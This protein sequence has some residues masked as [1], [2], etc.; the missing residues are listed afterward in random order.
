MDCFWGVAEPDASC[1]T[2]GRLQARFRSLT[3][4]HSD[5]DQKGRL[6]EIKSVEKRLVNVQTVTGQFSVSH[7]KDGFLFLPPFFFFKKPELL[8]VAVRACARKLWSQRRRKWKPTNR[9]AAAL[10]PPQ[11]RRGANECHANEPDRLL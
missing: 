10:F 8:C 1:T 6:Q 4:E 11:E 3:V 5:T 9:A 7:F 2:T